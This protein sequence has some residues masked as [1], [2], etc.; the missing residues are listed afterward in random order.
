MRAFTTISEIF[1]TPSYRLWCEGGLFV[2][3]EVASS[4]GDGCVS[5]QMRELSHEEG[6]QDFS[7]LFR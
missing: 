6:L 5:P 3:V 2:F 7:I 4:M 1:E